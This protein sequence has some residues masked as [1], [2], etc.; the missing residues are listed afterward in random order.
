MIRTAVN[1]I[2]GDEC[3]NILHFFGFILTPNDKQRVL[4]ECVGCVTVCIQN[5]LISRTDNT[6]VVRIN[7]SIAGNILRNITETEGN[8]FTLDAP[9]MC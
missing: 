1:N 6:F 5:K 8:V 9:R 3:I 7:G 2:N 4:R